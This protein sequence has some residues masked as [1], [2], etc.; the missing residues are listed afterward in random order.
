MQCATTG[1]CVLPV[2]QME[3]VM[4]L[5]NN[6]HLPAP[7]QQ[8]MLVHCWRERGFNT[9]PKGLHAKWTLSSI[10]HHLAF[11]YWTVS[12]SHSY[13]T[14]SFWSS[15]SKSSHKNTSMPPTAAYLHNDPFVQPCML[16]SLQNRQ[17][18]SATSKWH[19]ANHNGKHFVTCDVPCINKMSS[20]IALESFNDITVNGVIQTTTL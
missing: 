3:T 6:G 13:Y 16:Q 8:C 4:F 2:L 10:S 18:R 9:Q 11:T 12:T 1:W 20:E 17:N 5:W 15:S 7:E 19:V 14:V